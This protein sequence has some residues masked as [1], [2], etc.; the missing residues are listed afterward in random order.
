MSKPINADLVE[1]GWQD[2]ARWLPSNL[3][4][5]AQETSGFRRRRG[6][7]SA[8]DLVRIA[9]AYALLDLSLRSVS[10]WM[11]THGLG[12]VSDVAVLGRLRRGARFLEAIVAQM[13]TRQLWQAPTATLPYRVRLVD[14]TTVSAPGAEGTEWRLHVSYDAARGV[15]DGVTLTDVH[16][17]EHLERAT[18]QAG[19]IL[20]GDRGY[21]HAARIRT[22]RARGAHVVIRLGHSAVPLTDRTGAPVDPLAFARRKRP[23]AGRPPR[24]EATDVYLRDDSERT[25]PLRLIVVRKTA[26]ATHRE[27]ERIRREAGRKGKAVTDRSLAA[28]A[29]A[30]L[31]TS[32]PA[33]EVDAVTIAELYRVRWQIEL[34]FKRWKSL[35]ALDALR[36]HDP[37]L[38]RAYLYAKL[39]AALLAD[40]LAR[41][42]RAFS[43]WGAPLSPHE[44]EDLD[45]GPSGPRRRR[46]RIHSAPAIS[47]A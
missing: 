2:A 8:L 21:A 5:L 1:A 47:R 3:D 14:A 4:A 12:D 13:L 26:E 34:N 22:A 42:A 46:R 9:L 7:R 15:V 20:V 31:L 30:F 45:L 10:T 36:A 40:T 24:V 32:L 6:V 27:R 38:A 29:F 17:G 16:G 19:E 28:A 44:L 18:P 43:P 39:I 41:A 11:A 23:R 33:D 35:L 37:D 25:D